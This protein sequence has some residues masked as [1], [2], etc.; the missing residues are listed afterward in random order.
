VPESASTWQVQ[1]WIS[2]GSG[3]AGKNHHAITSSQEPS[4]PKPL[5]LFRRKGERGSGPNALHLDGLAVH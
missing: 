3:V 1:N 2:S 4:H 5:S